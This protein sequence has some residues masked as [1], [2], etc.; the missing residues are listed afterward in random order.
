MNKLERLLKLLAALLDTAVPLSAEDLRQRIGGYP[1]RDES[2]RRAFERDKDDLRSSG[3]T[4]LVKPV[5]D[6]DPPIDGYLVDQDEYAGCDPGLDA[7]EL[8]A[9]HLAAALVRVE[10][11]GDDALWKLGGRPTEEVAPGGAGIQVG[12]ATD[13]N[14]AGRGRVGVRRLPEDLLRPLR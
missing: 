14:T 1:D 9:L 5:P 3:I 10:E 7:D 8:A 12:P 6:T 13:T 11:M 4:I 2:F